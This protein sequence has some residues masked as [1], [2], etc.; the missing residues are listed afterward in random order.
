MEEEPLVHN[1]SNNDKMSADIT[2]F[3]D[4]KVEKM[5][6]F[7]CKRDFIQKSLLNLFPGRLIMERQNYNS[8]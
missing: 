1:V 3:V 6:G 8:S 7:P 4:S 2:R 5:K